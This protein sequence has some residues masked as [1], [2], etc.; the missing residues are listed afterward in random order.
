M[1]SNLMNYLREYRNKSF[2]E[3]PFS[4]VDA[5]LLS[6]LSYLKMDGIVPGF[7]RGGTIGFAELLSYPAAEHLFSDPVY[8]ED[9][10]KI[11]ALMSGSRRYGKLRFGYFTQYHDAD[12]ETQFAAV[13]FFLGV[14]SIFLSFRG[15]DETLVGWKE[16]FNMAYMKSVPSQRLALAYLREA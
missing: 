16:D 1:K 9:Y 8:G 4:E 10:R 14:T 6:N 2:K 12:R 15:T 13:T 11:I 5:L 7:E 3:H